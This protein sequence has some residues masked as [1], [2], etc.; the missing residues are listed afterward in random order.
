MARQAF[1][2]PI[3]HL[4]DDPD[5]GPEAAV[6]YEDGGL[7]VEDGHVAE[8]GPFIEV[9]PFLKGAPLTR[10]T[11]GLIVPGFID[12]HVH[13]PQVDMMA[14]PGKNLLHW[15]SAYAFPAESRFYHEDVAAEAA[16]FFLDQLLAHG[17]TSALVFATA[18]KVSAE[19]LFAEA[20]ARNMRL[21]TGKVLMD[22]N[23][24][25]GISDTAETGFMESR[26]LIREWHGKG[27]LGYAVTPRFALTS[28]ERQLELAGRLLGEHQ[29]VKLHTH[30]SENYDELEAVKKLYPDC[31]DY[32]GVYEKF[33]LATPQS[34]FAHCLHLSSSEW[35]RMGQAGC[36]VAHCPTSNLF[37][38]SGLFNLTDAEKAGV[39]TGLASDVG[40]GTSLSLLATMNEAYKVHQLQQR[41]LSA[42]KLFYLATLGAARTLRLDD[43]IGNLTPGKEADFLILDAKALPVL[44]RRWERSSSLEEKLF[45]LAILGDDRA[46]AATYVAGEL[47]HKR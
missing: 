29:G 43:K 44:Q 16:R 36:G 33:G 11:D 15:L 28:S 10:V 27:R 35:Q 47:A 30:L 42:F 19:A 40:A 21:I 22:V 12:C 32:F 1:R 6:I 7:L 23:A 46:V 25:A 14:S 2:G 20:F 13:F 5:L 26:S 37:L 3:F 4:L 39:R 31:P 38:G 24:P 34:V 8:V 41:R 17:T 9:Q 18:H 45:A